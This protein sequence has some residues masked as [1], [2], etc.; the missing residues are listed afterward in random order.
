MKKSQFTDSQIL[1]ALKQSRAGAP[2]PQL[3]SEHGIS[4]V[5]FCA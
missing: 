5:T 1:A 4:P 2:A 3:C